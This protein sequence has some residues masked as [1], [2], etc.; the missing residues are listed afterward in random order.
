MQQ[1]AP[2]QHGDITINQINNGTANVQVAFTAFNPIKGTLIVE[3]I[4][5]SEG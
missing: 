3:E 2:L 1:L 5:Y 4:Q